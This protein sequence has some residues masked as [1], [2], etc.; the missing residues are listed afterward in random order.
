MKPRSLRTRLTLWCFL[1][2]T[3]IISAADYVI[4]VSL[5]DVVADEL[6]TALLSRAAAEVAAIKNN[7]SISVNQIDDTTFSDPRFVFRLIQVVDDQGRIIAESKQLT[8][9]EPLLTADELNF[10]LGGQELITSSFITGRPLRVA[11][12]AGQKHG[13]RY[14]IAVA[15]PMNTINHATQRVAVILILVGVLMVAAASW[16][17]YQI[18]H[19]A[20]TPVDHI[21]QRAR[22]IGQGNLAQRIQVGDAGAEIVKLAG[23]LNEMLDK[24][25]RLFESQKQFTT[26]A[27]HEIRSPLAALRCRL[28]VAARQLRSATEYEEVIKHS[29]KEVVRLSKLADDLL[30]LARADAGH[31]PLE[32]REV[33]LADLL[34][35]TCSDMME[36]ASAH[37]V[38][39]QLQIIVPKAVYAD[40][41]QLERVFRNLIENGIKYSQNSGH[42]TVQTQLSGDGQW[43]RIDIKDN[44]LG[45]A[46]L[47]LEKVF[48]RF[49]RID[50]AHS[51]KTEGT[52]LGLAICDQV[53][54][55]H[56]GRIE[57]T[58]GI[59][60]GS[61]FSVF[62]PDAAI[63]T[64]DDDVQTTQ[65]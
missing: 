58:S 6:D 63:L 16:G 19:R 9:D 26:D 48:H 41:S 8:T 65:T 21:V 52:G 30:L 38:D 17:G 11:A 43:A 22:E 33:A 35:D 12:L 32:L 55:A 13:A 34:R 1:V 29:L 44:G 3:L 50:H 28:E 47:E 53:I 15:V 46:E 51:T 20:L 36:L 18:I 37:G 54:K 5:K 59:G 24:L 10:V 4:Y 31:V 42:G 45:I 64:C 23:V 27:S 61:I 40:R 2:F 60:Q 14:V 57:V 39:L 49:Y 25:E 56:G 62:L 7:P